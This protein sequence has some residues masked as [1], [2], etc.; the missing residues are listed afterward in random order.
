MARAGEANT[1]TSSNTGIVAGPGPASQAT[2]VKKI[3]LE[4]VIPRRY[5]VRLDISLVFSGASRSLFPSRDGALIERASNFPRYAPNW[6]SMM[7]I[8]SFYSAQ[9]YKERLGGRSRAEGER[10]GVIGNGFQV[11][12]DRNSFYI[13]EAMNRTILP[14]FRSATFVSRLSNVRKPCN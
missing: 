10:G 3:S 11:I 4:G 13:R 12:R 1:T 8:H 5:L 14:L 6:F 7:A 2:R 9:S